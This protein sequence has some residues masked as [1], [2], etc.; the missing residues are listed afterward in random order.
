MFPNIR[1]MVGALFA[2]VVALTC[3][4]GLFAAFRVNHEPL[5]RLPAGTAP[6]QFVANERT[7][8]GTPFDGQSHLNGPQHSAIATDV[9]A[10]APAHQMKAE[11]A[12]TGT[13]EAIKP[14]VATIPVID[15]APPRAIEQP[16]DV[17]EP[18][19]SILSAAPAAPAPQIAPA[20]TTAMVAPAETAA[21][22]PGSI[23]ATPSVQPSESEPQAGRAAPVVAEP[24]S[25]KP[26]EEEAAA[27]P[28]NDSGEAVNAAAPAI[29]AATP[30]DQPS[31]V[32]PPASEAR[33]APDAVTA[34]AKPEE[35]VGK[36]E[37]KKDSKIARKPVA[38]RRFAVRRRVVRRL[39]PA[40]YNGFGD[41]VFRSAPNYS[42]T[43]A[44]RSPASPSNW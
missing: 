44:S 12:S 28:D 36:T 24:S 37:A 11:A 26:A 33:P 2:S 4:F 42:N 10:A 15:T 16:A 14:V 6:I 18:V 39:L 41:P 19:V 31:A 25:T 7:G 22:S 40:Q 20:P 43:S 35:P 30:A 17:I 38:R 9:S 32:A 34:S 23:T 5:S 21:K 3:G 8:W 29:T 13:A 1:L 27:K